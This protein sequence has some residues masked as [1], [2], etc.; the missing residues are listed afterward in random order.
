[1]YN[2]LRIS[3]IC[4]GKKFSNHC[5]NRLVNVGDLQLV[6]ITRIMDGSVPML[7]C[8]SIN[9]YQSCEECDEKKL[10]NQRNVSKDQTQNLKKFLVNKSLHDLNLMT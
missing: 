7:S 9:C 3:S 10:Y 2:L 8:V 4:S 5:R 6:K 1:M